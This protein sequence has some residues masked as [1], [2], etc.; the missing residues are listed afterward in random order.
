MEK[1][2]RSR[3]LSRLHFHILCIFSFLLTSC[4]RQIQPTLSNCSPFRFQESCVYILQN[5]SMMEICFKS[6]NWISKVL[7]SLSR[8]CDSTAPQ[9][10]TSCFPV[11]KKLYACNFLNCLELVMVSGNITNLSKW[12]QCKSSRI[13][14]QL[15]DGVHHKQ[16]PSVWVAVQK[17]IHHILVSNTEE[18]ENRQSHIA[19]SCI[20][21]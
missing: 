20:S 15:G 17:Y 7:S 4:W 19:Q 16:L 3:K 14:H 8:A 1:P 21:N 6:W 18:E 5:R 13:L 2:R 10:S 9:F 11:K 12:P